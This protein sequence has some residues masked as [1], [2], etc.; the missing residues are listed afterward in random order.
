M[1]KF[2]LVNKI[3]PTYDKNNNMI[4]SGKPE[5]LGPIIMEIPE[6]DLTKI[7]QL[8]QGRKEK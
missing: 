6:D 1:E 3:E 4:D 8:L 2:I 5:L 7:H